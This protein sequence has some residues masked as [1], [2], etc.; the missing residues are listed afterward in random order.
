MKQLAGRESEPPSL[1]DGLFRR[2][3]DL[4]GRN[5]G[6]GLR[7][8][9]EELI[10]EAQEEGTGELAPEQR[11]LLLNALSF[12]QLRVDDVMVPRTEI[13]CVAVEARLTTVVEAMRAGGHTRLVV[14]RETLDDV[15]GIVHLKDLL[16]F[17]GDGSAFHLEA[18]VR[19]VL[20]V[21]TS[22]RIIDLLLEMRD[23]RMHLAIVIDE[24][25][26]TD[27]LVTIE[28]IVEELVGELQTSGASA[29]SDMM[30]QLPDGS[31]E[32]DARI[33]LEDLER[34]LDYRFVTGGG[35]GRIGHARGTY[36]HAGRPG[37]AT[38]RSDRASERVL[39]HRS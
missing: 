21:P 15:L 28:D 31:M 16:A 32:A 11:A 22:A 9:L 10:E 13:A 4:A 17:W 34:D 8:A 19:P 33:A 24:F 18:V 3:R 39:L 7:E 2:L 20:V 38:G 29:L 1:W 37:P 14:Y 26:G 5:E 36:R 12:G 35:T 27:G 25:G 30:K 23:A 6:M